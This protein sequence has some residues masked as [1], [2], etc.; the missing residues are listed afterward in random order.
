PCSFPVSTP[1]CPRLVLSSSSRSCTSPPPTP[2]LSL[3]DA[4]PIYARKGFAKLSQFCV[5]FCGNH[6]VTAYRQ[7][8]GQFRRQYGICRAAFLDRKSTR[9]NSSHVSISYAVFC[10]KQKPLDTA[11][12]H[13]HQDEQTT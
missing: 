2:P 9:L 8:I 4:L 12:S 5:G 3:H 7:N 11:M 6:R 1:S 10:L 13:T